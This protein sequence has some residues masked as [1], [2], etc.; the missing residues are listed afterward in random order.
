MNASMLAEPERMD[1]GISEVASIRLEEDSL[2]LSKYRHLAIPFHHLTCWW[3]NDRRI[4]IVFSELE[5]MD[6]E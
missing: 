2:F 5:I 6:F 1:W 3:E 4:D